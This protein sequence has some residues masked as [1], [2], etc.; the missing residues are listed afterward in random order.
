MVKQYPYDL[1]IRCA[2]DDVVFDDSFDD[3]FF[4]G[5]DEGTQDHYNQETGEW[6]VASR[7]WKLLTKCRDDA[8]SSGNK[9]ETTDGQVYVF[10]YTIYLPKGLIKVPIGANIE[11]KDKN[12]NTRASGEIIKFYNGQLHSIIWV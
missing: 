9:I 1:F 12:G 3:S 7:T 11:V 10:S 8:N 5:S 4:K 2:V 6:I